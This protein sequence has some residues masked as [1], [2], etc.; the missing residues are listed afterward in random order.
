MV[1]P[2]VGPRRR[3]GSCRHLV[4]FANAEGGTIVVGLHSGR[5]EG[6]DA[7]PVGRT[8]CARWRWTSPLRR[9]ALRVEQIEVLDERGARRTLLALLVEPGEQVH[10]TNRGDCYLRVGDESRRLAFAQRQELVYDRGAAKYDG[11][12]APDAGADA[13]DPR[14][15]QTYASAMGSTEP[16][17][18]LDRPRPA[19][20]GPAAHH[21]RMPAVG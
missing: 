3:K 9:F 15:V 19:H 21:R 20:S 1:R 18:L 7:I 8:S 11:E 14:Q 5:V 6:A 17:R 13:L 2:E 4:A 10:E 16:E 12:A